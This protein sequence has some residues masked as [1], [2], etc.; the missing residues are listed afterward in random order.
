MAEQITRVEHDDGVV[1][2]GLARAPVNALSPDFLG[3]MADAIRACETD[4]T[5]RAIVLTS[6][7]KVYSAGLDL[8]EAQEFDLDAQFAIVEALNRDFL[9]LFACSK[10][11]VAAVNGAAIAGGLF[12]VLGADLRISAPKAAFGLAEVRVGANLP[13]GPMEIARASLDPNTLRRLLLTGQPIG[14]PEAL[15]RG[16]IDAIEEGD[17]T[18]RAVAEARTL[19][20][21]PPKAYAAVKRDLRADAIARIEAGMAAG[22]N[23]PE[24]GWFTDETKAAMAAMIG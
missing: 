3:E 20:A 2:L 10:P 19:G 18:T 15:Q 21:L 7:F 13:V 9:T 24:G 6:P 16:L 17:L 11:V 23:R 8:K 12:F 22:A 14:A 4:D 5:V 1:E